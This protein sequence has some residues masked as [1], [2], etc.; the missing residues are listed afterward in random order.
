MRY[1]IVI[2][3]G[4]PAGYVAAIRAGQLGKKTLLIEKTRVGGMCLNWGC[5]PTKAL[6]ESA[7]RLDEVRR[8]SDFGISGIDQAAVTFDWLKAASRAE[9]VV[10]RLTKGVEF[11]LKKNQVEIETGTA[12]LLSGSEISV[13]N[14]LISAGNIILATGT[15]PGMPAVEGLTADSLFPFQDLLKQAALPRQ[16][17][18]FGDGPSAIEMVQFFS[19]VGAQP[20]MLT[21]SDRLIPMADPFVSKT[22]SD[23][24]RKNKVVHASLQEAR[25]LFD[26]KVVMVGERSFKYDALINL[27]DRTPVLPSMKGFSLKQK[28]GFPI[29]DEHLQTSQPGV[30]AIGDV[31]GLSVFAH[32]ASAQGLFVVNHLAG[33]PGLYPPKAIPLNLYTWPEIAQVG[34]GEHQ[35][36][37]QGVEYKSA[38]FPL[39]ANGKSMAEGQNDGILRILYEPKYGEILGVVVVAPHATDMIA[40]AVA[41]IELEGTVADV[42]RMVHAHPTVSEVM[43][44]AALAAIDMPV[45][46]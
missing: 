6:L 17:V 30:Y 37:A 18:I 26:E 22:V 16:P 38:E 39:S 2:I 1:D 10:K 44:E 36:T 28:N 40:E 20:L 5:I 46:R 11:L 9:R 24:L 14:R 41:L 21:V 13:N 29:V 4:G 25:F 45:H 15:L 8:A 27:G 19:M 3:G 7:K 33:V 34:P 12:E 23:Q 43:M 35:L 32:A 31:N 42:A